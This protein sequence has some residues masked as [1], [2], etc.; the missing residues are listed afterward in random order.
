MAASLARRARE[1]TRAGLEKKGPVVYWMSRDQR[2]QDNWALLYAQHHANE[3]QVPLVVVFN[4]LP[5]FLGATARHFGFMLR[6]LAEVQ[7]DLNALNIPFV[8]LK[9]NAVPNVTSFVE[10]HE[11][12]LLVLDFS[13]LRIAKQWREEL[14]ETLPDTVPLHEVDAHNIAPCWLVSSKKE[15]GARTIRKKCWK[16]MEEFLTDFP[17]LEPHQYSGDVATSTV[18]VDALLGE[19]EALDKTVP[20]VADFTPGFKAGMNALQTFCKK[21]LATYATK[22]NAPHENGTS[23][24][25]PWF[26][27]GHL[28]TQRAVW[29]VMQ[30]RTQ[31]NKESAD[32]FVE[33]AF[34]RRELADNYCYYEPNYD[35]LEGAAGWARESL[36]LHEQDSREYTYTREQLEQC[37]THDDMWNAAQ[38]EMMACGKMHG[39]MRMYWAKKILEWSTSPSVALETAIYLNDRY[40][41]DGRDPNGYV[42]CMW[43]IAGVHDQGWKERSIFGKIRF[44]NYGGLE[45]KFKKDGIAKYIRRSRQLQA[46]AN[47]PPPS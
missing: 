15:V 2:V 47:Y 44:M 32:A 36:Q 27:F 37:E 28:S 4:L 1:L 46:K 6:G 7:V 12:S 19:M 21:H 33:E 45:R 24:L 38:R 22:R 14:Q 43:S 40:N 17:P 20:E 42:G 41:L 18:D 11:A 31:K 35:S 5:S 34:V 26:H 39:Y 29:E 30:V 9:G 8:M 23:N 16:Q 13:P 3:L 10:T 25:S